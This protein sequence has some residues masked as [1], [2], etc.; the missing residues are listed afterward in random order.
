MI[1]YCGRQHSVFFKLLSSSPDQQ[2]GN[3]FW[4]TTVWSDLVQLF[5]FFFCLWGLLQFGSSTSCAW[6]FQVFCLWPPKHPGSLPSWGLSPIPD[7]VSPVNTV[8][9]R[10]VQ[11]PLWPRCRLE[12]HSEI[13]FCV[14]CTSSAKAAVGDTAVFLLLVMSLEFLFCPIRNCKFCVYKSLC[15]SAFYRRKPE[16]EIRNKQVLCQLTYRS[17]NKE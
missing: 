16:V 8:F 13:V 7:W 14:C 11:Y 5:F 10:S 3:I 17:W 6:R 9:P 12:H 1:C 15:F 2:V 4:S